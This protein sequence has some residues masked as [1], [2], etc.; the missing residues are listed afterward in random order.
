LVR[1]S[2]ARDEFADLEDANEDELIAFQHEFEERRR[3]GL[4]HREAVVTAKR[5]VVERTRQAAAARTAL[6]H[7]A[8]KR[9]RSLPFFFSRAAS[10]G[11]SEL[12]LSTTACHQ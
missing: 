8:P 3:R 5:S 9:E 6:A 10:D 4:E 1:A 7:A 11:V 12:F 2:S